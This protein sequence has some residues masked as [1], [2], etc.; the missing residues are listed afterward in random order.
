MPD[1]DKHPDLHGNAPDRC[2]AALLLVDVLN[3]LRFEG[4]EAFVPRAV[5]VGRRIVALKQSARKA[6]IPV[7][8]VNDNAGRWRSDLRQVI[9][10]SQKEDAPGRS[11]A[12]L[13]VPEPPDYVVLKPKHSGFYSTTLDTLLTYLRTRRLI[14][15]GLTVERCLL[16]TA[17][18]GFLRDYELF[19]P[20]DCTTAIDEDDA[21]AAFR[22]LERVLG[23]NTTPSD[24]LDLHRLVHEG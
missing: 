17:N 22:I 19:V 18:D 14:L 23:A 10:D 21:K 3:A 11:L 8:Y 16:F 24:E 9:D 20:R 1:P 6:G 15:T 12:R 5:E 4:S 13:F 2:P 7:V